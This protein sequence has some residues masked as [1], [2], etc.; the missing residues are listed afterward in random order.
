MH[1]G[2]GGMSY[3]PGAGGGG[4]GGGVTSQA[5]AAATAALADSGILSSHHTH[6][7][8]NSPQR[9]PSTGNTGM[10]LHVLNTKG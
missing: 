5:L 8:R 2:P 7:H 6:L 10:C 1:V 4:G 9:P 3:S